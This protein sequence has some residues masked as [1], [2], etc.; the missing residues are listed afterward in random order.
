MLTISTPLASWIREHLTWQSSRIEHCRPTVTREPAPLATRGI[1]LGGILAL[2]THPRPTARIRGGEL[3]PF[4]VHCMVFVKLY[5]SASPPKM[6]TTQMHDRSRRRPRRR[7]MMSGR[8]ADVELTEHG[9]VAT[10]LAA[11]LGDAVVSR[12]GVQLVALAAASCAAVS[13]CTCPHPV[14][15][16]CG[17]ACSCSCCGGISSRA[18]PHPTLLQLVPLLLLLLLLPPHNRRLA[19]RPAYWPAG[20]H[21]SLELADL[22]MNECDPAVATVS[23]ATGCR[24]VLPQMEPP[25]TAIRR[26]H[27]DPPP[28]PPRGRRIRL[29]HTREELQ[30]RH[31]ILWDVVRQ[32]SLPFVCLLLCSQL[33]G[34]ELL[35]CSCCSQ[36]LG[37]DTASRLR[38]RYWRRVSRLDE[39]TG[40]A[41][42][43]ADGR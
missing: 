33:L 16:C 10:T 6:T 28:S 7:S 38:R 17:L 8:P 34:Y 18:P 5:Q 1:R 22:A 29:Y 14:A 21:S 4:L 30:R 20:S 25:A 3:G 31:D 40:R 36:T 35:C 41:D 37:Y 9:A 26:R 42:G 19:S 12:S 27:R 32:V 13:F 43:R 2:L 15:V 39:E 11:A 24:V 23:C